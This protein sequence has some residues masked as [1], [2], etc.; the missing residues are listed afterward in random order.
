MSRAIRY[1]ASG[2]AQWLLRSKRNPLFADAEHGE[3]YLMVPILSIEASGIIWGG[4]LALSEGLWMSSTQA[5]IH[6]VSCSDAC[7]RPHVAATLELKR[8]MQGV[9][10][11]SGCSSCW[12]HTFA[13][14]DC[15]PWVLPHTVD[16]LHFQ[17]T[18]ENH[19][20]P[21]APKINLKGKR[22]AISKSSFRREK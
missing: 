3:D 13:K 10:D 1:H 4:G 15:I 22:K 12:W 21:E 7:L 19:P 2:M 6:T 18:L 17:S 14:P 5:A 11:D 20:S 16:Q 9:A 8:A